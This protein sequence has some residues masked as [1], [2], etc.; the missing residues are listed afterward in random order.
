[1]HVLVHYTCTWNSSILS[2]IDVQFTYSCQY[3][4]LPTCSFNDGISDSN[5]F[6]P[7]PP[8]INQGN[9]PG[10]LEDIDLYVAER[11]LRLS[12][13]DFNTNDF[14]LRVQV[15]YTMHMYVYVIDTQKYN[16]RCFNATY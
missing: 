14:F 7:A 6:C 1:M 12:G 9:R 5:S 4:V 8:P 15:K 11:L 10:P 2:C 13:D 3:E 16:V